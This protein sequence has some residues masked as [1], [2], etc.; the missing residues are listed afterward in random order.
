[1]TDIKLQ[2]KE[3]NLDTLIRSLVLERHKS[4]LLLSIS[5]IIPP[6]V[7]T[8]NERLEGK[9]F[10]E[11]DVIL[12]TPGGYIESAYKI[13]KLLRKHAKKINVIVPSYAKSAG[14]LICLCADKLILTTTSE[15]GP[16]DVQIPEHQE[17]DIDT[18]KS[19]LNGYK[20]LEQV[21]NHAIENMDV[22]TMLILRRTGNKMKLH[23][24]IKLAIEFSGNTSGCLYNQINPK[25]ISEYARALEIGERYGVKI[26]EKYMGW[27]HEKATKV[28]RNLVYNY[29]SHEFII[30]I[31]E[32]TDLDFIVEE[33]QGIEE[34]L[35][36]TIGL[37]LEALNA[38]RVELIEPAI[39]VQKKLE[40]KK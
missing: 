31:E 16:L 38:D 17:G 15:L 25:M 26:L 10:Q 33:S 6:V 28:V 39:V 11:L 2:Q 35:I 40:M 29:P 3:V 7:A 12:H 20:A 32:L 19:A 18:Y 1:M 21:Q 13:A 34:K 27:E 22:A 14:T 36:E 37:S 9:N 23:D 8:L 4:A 5:N 30:D 24:A